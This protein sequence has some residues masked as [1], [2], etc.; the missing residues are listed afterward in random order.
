[1]LRVLVLLTYP[2]QNQTSQVACFQI[3]Q[4]IPATVTRL[5]STCTGSWQQ[6][7]CPGNQRRKGIQLCTPSARAL[8]APS[9]GA[10][11]HR[12]TYRTSGTPSAS[13]TPPRLLPC[14]GK[15]II[16]LIIS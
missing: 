3:T 5:W 16:L 15:K 10:F 12:T 4:S 7:Y 14:F 9:S 11:L 2:N 6:F 13:P 1:M 8:Y